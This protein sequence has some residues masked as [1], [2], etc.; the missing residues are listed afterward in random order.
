MPNHFPEH[1]P[2]SSKC[3]GE[4]EIWHLLLEMRAKVKKLSEIKPP[5]AYI[6][7]NLKRDQGVLDFRLADVE[8][9]PA[10]DV[11]VRVKSKETL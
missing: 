3:S 9:D 11:S 8:E 1:F 5:L 6:L 7:T 10:V 4:R 2:F